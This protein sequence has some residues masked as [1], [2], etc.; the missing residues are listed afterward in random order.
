MTQPARLTALSAAI[1]SALLSLPAQAQNQQLDTV[2]VTDA[3]VPFRQFRGVEVTGTAIINPTARQALPVRV[4]D[5]RE[6]ERTGATNVVQLLQRLP[7]M[8]GFTELGGYNAIGKGGYQSGAIHGYEEGTLVLINGRRQA[9][10]P[11]QRADLDRTVADIGLLP[12]SA[13]DRVEILTDGA[14]SLYGS[15]AIAGVINIITREQTQGLRISAEAGEVTTAN[16]RGNSIGLAWGKGS[17]LKDRYNIQVHFSDNRRDPVAASDLPWTSQLTM[18]AGTNAAGE[19]LSAFAW[20]SQYG[21][22]GKIYR[23]SETADQCVE[24]Y[25]YSIVNQAPTYQGPAVYQC[26]VPA[27][28]D[29][30][31]Y[32]KVDSRQLHTQFEWITPSQHAI[33][34]EWTRQHQ[35]I[36]WRQARSFGRYVLNPETNQYILFNLALL[37]PVN[38][39]VETKRDRY[40]LGV[41]GLVGDWNYRLSLMS[42]NTRETAANHG[43]TNTTDFARIDATLAPYYA[44]LLKPINEASAAFLQT[45][46]SLRLKT[47]TVQ[48]IES[49]QFRELKLTASRSVA[50]TQW[51]DVQLALV[52]FASEQRISTAT[53]NYE[54]Y[55]PTYSTRRRNHGLASEIQWPALER[56]HLTGALR[57]ESYSDFGNVLTGKLGAKYQLTEH[58]FV[59]ASSGTGYR[60]PTLAQVAPYLTWVSRS[61]TSNTWAEGNPDL[62]P[63]TSTQHSI[64]VQSSPNHRWAMG[65][66]WWQFKVDDVFGSLSSVEVDRDPELRAR[67][68]R[69]GSY[70]L[71]TLNLG[72]LSK[73]GLDYNVQYRH[74]LDKGVFTLGL[75]GTH[76]LSSKRSL[77][78]GQDAV[79][80]LGTYQAAFHTV[81]PRNKLRLSGTIASQQ[82]GWRAAVNYQSG[83]TE[84]YSVY[85]MRPNGAAN[86]GAGNTRRVPHFATLD[87]GGWYNIHQRLRLVWNIENITNATPPLRTYNNSNTAN[88]GSVYPFSDTRYNDYRGR[89][90]NARLEWQLW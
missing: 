13:I 9:A 83:N 40:V 23:L 73:S 17:L 18:P 86:A 61:G 60:A 20:P 36:D 49:T 69:N 57:T 90:F 53:P 12:L 44:D 89:V 5:R 2:D 4:I 35:G 16:S 52:G 3:G 62:R 45:I 27:Y 77:R 74:P 80:D 30:Y 15:E 67:Y 28:P 26:L 38:Q 75:E 76:N 42:A 47:S 29:L 63:E 85:V 64:G 11:L 19:T 68:F 21:Y 46:D 78:S 48:T 24:G 22:P 41:K 37:F 32:P 84:P 79:S 81:T 43:Q 1:A 14:S 8:H 39:L 65:V 88:A 51:G 55:F 87:I 50:E 59:R 66:D 71:P 56:L 33:F 58:T 70:Y 31:L 6:I 7:L 72:Q 34:A 25:R 82:S 10:V 54:S